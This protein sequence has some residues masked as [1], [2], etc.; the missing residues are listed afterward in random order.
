MATKKVVKKWFT[1][2][3]HTG[4]HKGQS[5][6]YRRRLVRESHGGNYLTAAKSMLALSNVSK[7]ASTRKAA[8]VDAN[9]F[10]KMHARHK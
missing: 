8:R 9:Y 3:V 4:W 7:D 5:L 10:F 1:H 2:R 6:A